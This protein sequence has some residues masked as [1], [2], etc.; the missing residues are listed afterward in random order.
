[1]GTELVVETGGGENRIM[2]G[3]GAGLLMSMWTGGSCRE[4]GLVGWIM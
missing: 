4:E 1:M 3:G 2:Q